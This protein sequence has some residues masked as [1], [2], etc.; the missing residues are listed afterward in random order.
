MRPDLPVEL[1]AELADAAYELRLVA[2]LVPDAVGQVCASLTRVSDKLNDA[3]RLVG[4][5]RPISGTLLDLRTRI[6]SFVLAVQALD[7]AQPGSPRVVSLLRRAA[8][9]TLADLAAVA[10]PPV[11]YIEG[12][13]RV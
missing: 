1:P 12:A 8:D 2:T 7:E 4:L 6:D 11:Q 3:A 9:Q 10:S 5:D 13:A